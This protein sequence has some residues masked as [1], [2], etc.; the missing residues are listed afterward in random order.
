MTLPSIEFLAGDVEQLR[1]VD[2]G[3]L[4]ADEAAVEDQFGGVALLLDHGLQ[5][6]VNGA[7]ADDG[8][9]VDVPEGVDPV[10]AVDGLLEL[11]V[12]P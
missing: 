12:G 5:L 7:V 11:V 6:A 1:E 9:D 8:I 3:G 4:L 2:F 10:R